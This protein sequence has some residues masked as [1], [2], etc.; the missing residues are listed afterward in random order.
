MFEFLQVLFWDKGDNDILM[1]AECDS[2][3]VDN[4]DNFEECYYNPEKMVWYGCNVDKR[5]GNMIPVSSK[6]VLILK[7]DGRKSCFT[8]DE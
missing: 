7:L 6:P 1:V 4:W 5:T 2:L 3:P 8:K